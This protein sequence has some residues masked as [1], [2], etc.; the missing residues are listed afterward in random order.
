LMPYQ[1]Q[2]GVWLLSRARFIDGLAT[3]PM[4]A[5]PVDHMYHS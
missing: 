5:F 4:L 2:P 1:D 3:D